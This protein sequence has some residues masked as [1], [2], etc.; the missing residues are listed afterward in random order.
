M[1]AAEALRRH[2][3][4]SKPESTPAYLHTN[5]RPNRFGLRFHVA[6]T[7]QLLEVRPDLAPRFLA[8]V[9]HG[10][11]IGGKANR[12]GARSSPM[13]RTHPPEL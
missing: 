4:L 11:V 12:T 5:D 6:W 7:L 10:V 3:V 13:C 8:V 1:R 2:R 9:V